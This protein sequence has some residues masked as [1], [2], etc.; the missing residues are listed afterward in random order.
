MRF[1]RRLLGQ[2]PY[3]K[4]HGVRRPA[5]RA[6]RRR[7]AAASPQQGVHSISLPWRWDGG[8]AVLQSR[9]W[10]EGGYEQ[11]TRAQLVPRAAK[12]RKFRR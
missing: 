9:A 10:D 7:T 6:G 5:A 11:P 2:R 12:L 8:A 3:R 1:R 4:S